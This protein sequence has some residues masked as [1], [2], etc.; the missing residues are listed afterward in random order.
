MKLIFDL[1]LLTSIIVIGITVVT[2]EGMLLFWVREW[3]EEKKSKI[4]D[5]LIRC[6]WCMSSVWSLIGFL[7]ASLIGVINHFSWHL[8]FIYPIVVCGSS[9]VSGF[10]WTLYKKIEIQIKVYENEEQNLFFDL[11]DRKAKY[12]RETTNHH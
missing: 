8:I 9:F 10:F 2:Q 4:F 5:A 12:K 11:K 3:A 1:I 6:I 7:F